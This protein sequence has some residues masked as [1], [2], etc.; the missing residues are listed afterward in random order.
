MAMAEGGFELC[1]FKSNANE[2]VN[3]DPSEEVRLGVGDKDESTKVSIVS[4]SLLAP[5]TPHRGQSTYNQSSGAEANGEAMAWASSTWRSAGRTTGSW[6][7][8][9]GTAPQLAQWTTGIGVPQY[10]CREINQSVRKGETGVPPRP[11]S[12]RRRRISATAGFLVKPS[13]AGWQS[14]KVAL[15]PDPLKTA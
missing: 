7:S 11:H 8:G 6:S 9:T 13:I 14:V 10:R 12:V 2:V 1:K 4:V 3:M 5:P 15:A